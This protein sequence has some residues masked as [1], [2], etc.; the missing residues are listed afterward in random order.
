[1]K[2]MDICDTNPAS[3]TLGATAE[4]AIRLMIQ[5]RVGAVVVVD[6][7]G[8]VAGIFTERDVLTKLALSGRDPAQVPVRE[9]MTTPVEMATE[10]TSPVDALTVMMSRHYRHLPIADAAG[11]PI[12]MLSIRHALEARIANLVAE[13]E[14]G[15][16]RQGAV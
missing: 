14:A 4:N 1:M 8:I 12:G 15:R 7:A 9:L 5:Q 6:A 11:R 13:L 16:S 2:L 10:E 3:V